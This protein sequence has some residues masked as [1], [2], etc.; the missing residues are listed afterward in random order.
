MEKI[1]SL[2][3]DMIISKDKYIVIRC[4]GRGFGKAIEKSDLQKPYDKDFYKK[5]V[6]IATVTL[7][8]LFQCGFAFI[9]SDEISFVLPKEKFVL[10]NRRVEKLLSVVS[11]YI[12]GVGS[13]ELYELD[14]APVAFDAKIFEFEKTEDVLSY[15]NERKNVCFCN[16][17]F[18]IYRK[19]QMKR[20][21][22][23][24]QIA[25][26]SNGVEL[27]QLIEKMRAE[28]TDIYYLPFWQR[29]GSMIYFE[30]TDTKKIVKVIKSFKFCQEDLDNVEKIIN[31]EYRSESNDEK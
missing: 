11:G 3:G 23:S 21:D 10:Y 28:G 4:D 13:L 12:S 29:D 22:K 15:L 18:A 19:F 1:A 27:R 30:S 9:F 14:L 24:V 6:N 7:T 5:M 20:G 16:F 2:L 25:R 8:D 17:V 26:E 31:S